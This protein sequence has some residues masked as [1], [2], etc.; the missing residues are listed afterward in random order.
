MGTGRSY[1]SFWVYTEVRMISF[2]G[3]KWGDTSGS[4]RDIVVSKFRQR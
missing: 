3:E 2:V 4:T 1:I